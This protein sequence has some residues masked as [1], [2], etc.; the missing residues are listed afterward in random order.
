VGGEGI[1]NLPP[2]RKEL[3]YCPP[4]GK[5]LFY[6]PPLSL[7]QTSGGWGRNYFTAHLWGRKCFT[8][9]LW[10]RNCFTAHLWG[11]NFFLPTFELGPDERVWKATGLRE[12]HLL[13][14]VRVEIAIRTVL[15]LLHLV[16]A[17]LDER[18]GD[19]GEA[20]GGRVENDAVV[21]DPLAVGQHRLRA[22]V[23]L[24]P[25]V[26]LHCLQVHRAG[27]VVLTIKEVIIYS[28]QELFQFLIRGSCTFNSPDSET[29]CPNRIRSE[30]S[31]FEWNGH[32]RTVNY[33]LQKMYQYR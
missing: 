6:C 32:E 27:D 19:A 14:D 25:D 31:N 26:A 24:P 13:L 29:T 1:I 3:F 12:P 20:A 2:L 21:E 5:E 7:V 23:L 11:R 17:D 33:S 28:F 18:L 22:P 4:L 16:L 10:G 30:F 9:L 8:A 15:D